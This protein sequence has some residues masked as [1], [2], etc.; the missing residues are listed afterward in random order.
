MSVNGRLKAGPRLPPLP[1]A[2]SVL[3]SCLVSGSCLVSCGSAG[4]VA[5]GT[6]SVEFPSTAVAI[7]AVKQTQGVQVL[8]FSTA[9]LGDA[10]A[11]EAGACQGLIEEALTNNLTAVPDAMSAVVTPCDLL[12]GKGSVAVAYGNYAFLAVARDASGASY[13]VGCAEQTMSSSNTMVTIPL[14]LASDTDTVPTT[15]CT[16]L[17][18][19]CPSGGS[20]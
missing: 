4:N 13:L 16:S 3:A 1:A 14:S 18:Q 15:T 2:A 17:S 11:E 7:A 10:M 8:A 5:P 20:C 6:F 12:A 19:A 9:A